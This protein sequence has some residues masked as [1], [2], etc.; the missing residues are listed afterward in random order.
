[1]MFLPALA[2]AEAK[3]KPLPK[4]RTGTSVGMVGVVNGSATSSFD[5]KTYALAVGSPI[6]AGDELTTSVDGRLKL[7]LNDDTVINLGGNTKFVVAELSLKNGERKVNL[8]VTT[9][10]FLATVAKWFGATSDWN[11]STPTASAG[12]RGTTLWGDTD[13][14]AICA[15]YGTI[16]VTSKKGGDATKVKLDAGKCAAKMAEGKTEPLAPSA[17]QVAKYLSEVMPATKN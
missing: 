17:D 13:V 16:E 10:R 7:L 12:V 11:V 9:G 2:F 4:N 5:G 6:M 8:V 3:A 1:M 14:D 15:L